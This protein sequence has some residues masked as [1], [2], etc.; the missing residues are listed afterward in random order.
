MISRGGKRSVDLIHRWTQPACCFSSMAKTTSSQ[1]SPER[2]KIIPQTL[3]RANILCWLADL[4]FF[5]AM[6]SCIN[7]WKW[8]TVER[9]VGS[10]ESDIQKLHQRAVE[11]RPA[12]RQPCSYSNSV[13]LNNYCRIYSR[14]D[15]NSS[16]L[17]SLFGPIRKKCLTTLV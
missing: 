12:H 16:H 15:R 8:T 11:G 6:Q 10:V 9:W 4:V 17:W 3:L 13:S 2:V 7:K 14:L 5:K 1:V